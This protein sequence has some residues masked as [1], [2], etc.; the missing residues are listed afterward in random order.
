[1]Y[2]D[3]PIKIPAQASYKEIRSGQAGP[4]RTQKTLEERRKSH[5]QLV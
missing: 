1:M 5:N 3:L 2:F 4:G